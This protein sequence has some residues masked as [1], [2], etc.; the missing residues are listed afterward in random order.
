MRAFAPTIAQGEDMSL[1]ERRIGG[2]ISSPRNHSLSAEKSTIAYKVIVNMIY[3]KSFSETAIVSKKPKQK[4]TYAALEQT[5][6]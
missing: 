3:I 1:N 2:N 4:Q 6:S 5:N